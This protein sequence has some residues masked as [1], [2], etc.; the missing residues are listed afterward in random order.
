[1]LHVFSSYDCSNQIKF[2]DL[3]NIEKI[4]ENRDTN[5]LTEFIHDKGNA[6]YKYQYFPDFGCLKN[7][8]SFNY[9]DD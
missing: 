9:L 6:H 1:M 4:L 3:D 7:R 8:V 5:H 2:T